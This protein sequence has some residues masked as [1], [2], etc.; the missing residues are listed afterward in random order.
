VAK[1]MPGTERG[2]GDPLDICVLSERPISRAEVLLQARVVGGL[3]MRDRG[4]ADDK[5]LSILKDDPAF[6]AIEDVRDIPAALL[7]RL[8]HYFST[9]KLGRD[10]ANQVTVGAPYGREHAESVIRASLEDYRAE[11]GSAG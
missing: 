10:N 11:F 2:D 7:D 3:P 4:E 1:L 5:I 6:G 9:Y 8:M